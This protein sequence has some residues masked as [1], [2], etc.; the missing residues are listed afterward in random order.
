MPER[1]CGVR[2]CIHP[3]HTSCTHLNVA[4]GDTERMRKSTVLVSISRVW[5]GTTPDPG[6]GWWDARQRPGEEGFEAAGWLMADQ[7]GE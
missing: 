6:A 2:A 3:C 1:V 7:A 4:N 5:L